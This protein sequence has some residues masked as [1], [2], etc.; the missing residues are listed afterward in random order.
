MHIYVLDFTKKLIFINFP[1]TDLSIMALIIPLLKLLHSALVV[2]V[3]FLLYEVN[4]TLPPLFVG[5]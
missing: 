5:L 1:H 4:K 2:Y 3:T